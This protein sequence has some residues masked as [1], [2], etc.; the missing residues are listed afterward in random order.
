[1][2]LADYRKDKVKRKIDYSAPINVDSKNAFKALTRI[3]KEFEVGEKIIKEMDN[4][5][6]ILNMIDEFNL[7]DK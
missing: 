3:N 4:D 1:M 6:K 7:K 2:S 5:T